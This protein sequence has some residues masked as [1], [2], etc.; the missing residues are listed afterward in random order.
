MPKAP[1]DGLGA[2]QR[3]CARWAHVVPLVRAW[4]R[5]PVGRTQ[6]PGEPQGGYTGDTPSPLWETQLLP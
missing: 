1:S 5:V 2:L 4:A 3:P 6:S